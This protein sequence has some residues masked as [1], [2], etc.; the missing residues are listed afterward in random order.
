MSAF[1]LWTAPPPAREFCGPM[2]GDGEIARR[3]STTQRMTRLA[4][5]GQSLGRN[6]LSV[7]G[8][9]RTTGDLGIGVVCPLMTHER[10]KPCTAAMDLMPVLA[11]TKV[12]V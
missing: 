9:E 10:Q 3:F 1:D 6:S 12:L 2:R 5:S 4:Q 7:I 8:Q 11:P